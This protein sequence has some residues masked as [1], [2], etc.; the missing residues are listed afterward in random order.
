M[1][2]VLFFYVG[3][4]SWLYGGYIVILWCFDGGFFV[5]EFFFKVLFDDGFTVVAVF[6]ITACCVGVFCCLDGFRLVQAVTSRHFY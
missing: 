3:D 2:S 5:A 4:G 6:I 1:I